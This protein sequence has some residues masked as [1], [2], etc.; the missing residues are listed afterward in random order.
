[1]YKL[2]EFIPKRFIRGCSTRA[3]CPFDGKPCLESRDFSCFL[4]KFTSVVVKY[5]LS[6][7]LVFLRN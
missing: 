3:V 1:M 2:F 7:V 6:N 5:S 4:K